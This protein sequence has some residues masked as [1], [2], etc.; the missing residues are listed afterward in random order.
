M[1]ELAS[2]HA[3]SVPLHLIA[4]PDAAKIF[5][6]S[7]QL[8]IENSIWSSERPVKS[9]LTVK[10]S[11]LFLFL[12]VNLAR[13]PVSV[14]SSSFALA[15]IQPNKT[16]TASKWGHACKNCNLIWDYCRLLCSLCT[17][18]PLVHMGCDV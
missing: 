10:F 13:I 8:E 7:I 18:K 5:A 14:L 9:E 1:G 17:C 12:W 16:T 11:V 15:H 3:D 6:A 4:K 2:A